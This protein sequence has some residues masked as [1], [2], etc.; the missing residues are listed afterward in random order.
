MAL[1]PISDQFESSFISVPLALQI[2]NCDQYELVSRFKKCLPGHEPILEAGCGSGRWVAWFIKQGWRATGLDWSAALCERAQHEIPDGQFVQGDMRKMPFA[3]ESFGAL[4]SLGAIEHALEGPMGLLR[5]YHRV[6][7][8]GGILIITVPYLGPVRRVMRTL[9]LLAK[10]ALA[11]FRP[12]FAGYLRC[13]FTHD[14]PW[15]ADFFP[16]GQ[17]RWNFFQ[18]NF[19]GPEMRHFLEDS[20]FSILEETVDFGDEGL[21]HNFGRIVGRYDACSA[22]VKFNI[23]GK[24]LGKALPVAWRGHM[25]C[26]VVGNYRTRRN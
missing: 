13:Q 4:V 14:Q 3:D 24:V 15:A 10:L 12:H 2:A 22:C 11:L 7:R 21:L 9:R 6:L 5:E 17:G 25:L 19:T 16:D 26:Y 23:L 8:P 20:H 18:Y 1:N